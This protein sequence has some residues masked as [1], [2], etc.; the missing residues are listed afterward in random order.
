M[1]LEIRNYNSDHF[2]YCLVVLVRQRVQ[3]ANYSKN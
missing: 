3:L 2:Y 1:K